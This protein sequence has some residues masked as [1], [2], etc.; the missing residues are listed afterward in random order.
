MIDPDQIIRLLYRRMN[1]ILS[2]AELTIPNERQ[3]EAFRKRFLHELGAD[4]FQKDLVD[5]FEK[6][7]EEGRNTY[8]GKEVK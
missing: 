6:E 8:A 4:G 1:I 3:Y 5:L 7:K 2:N